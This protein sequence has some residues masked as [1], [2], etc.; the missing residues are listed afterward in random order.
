MCVRVVLGGR[1]RVKR[2]GPGDEWC[3]GQS[4]HATRELQ[5]GE[6]G[7]DGVEMCG[8]GRPIP[9]VRARSRW[10]QWWWASD[11]G[12]ALPAR[13]AADLGAQGAASRAAACGGECEQASAR[14][15]RGRRQPRTAVSTRA[16]QAGAKGAERG[17]EQGALAAVVERDGAAQDPKR[18]G[19]VERRPSGRNG[20]E[21]RTT[22]DTTRA[23]A[24]RCSPTAEKEYELQVQRDRLKLGA[25]L[26]CR[27]NTA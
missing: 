19:P 25:S 14:P 2:H 1:R 10:R 17:D 6:V 3:G 15:E 11:G 22:Q 20:S 16:A 4:A 24:R 13:D 27:K 8:C 26:A 18:T 9:R 21:R 5:L 23:T 12:Q 7:D